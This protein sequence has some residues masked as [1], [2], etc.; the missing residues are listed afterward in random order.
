M[1]GQVFRWLEAVEANSKTNRLFENHNLVKARTLMNHKYLGDEQIRVGLV[2]ASMS[3]YDYCY[4]L[5]INM[6]VDPARA[7]AAMPW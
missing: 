2:Q 4:L 3:E 6:V 5:R 1:D 7:T